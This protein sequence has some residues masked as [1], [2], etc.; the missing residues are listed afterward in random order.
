MGQNVKKP[1]TKTKA[2]CVLL[3]VAVVLIGLY[4]GGCWLEQRSNKPEPRGDYQE[5]KADE[6][7]VTYNNTVYRQRKNLTSILLMGIDH[8]SGETG[9]QADFLQLIVIDDTAKTVKRLPIDRVRK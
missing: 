8:D 2:V 5:R 9:G 1:G 4:Q 3:I 7:T 6:V